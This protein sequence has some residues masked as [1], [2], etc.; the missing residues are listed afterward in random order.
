MA[1]YAVDVEGKLSQRQHL[2]W[3]GKDK[4]EAGMWLTSLSSQSKSAM[5]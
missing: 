5:T 4:L 2:F 1:S 3:W